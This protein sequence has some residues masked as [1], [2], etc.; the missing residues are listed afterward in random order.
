MSTESYFQRFKIFDKQFKNHVLVVEYKE[1]NKEIKN[2]NYSNI[3]SFIGKVK[4]SKKS[5]YTLISNRAALM[6]EK[7]LENE[8]IEYNRIIEN[9]LEDKDKPYLTLREIHKNR[10]IGA[11]YKSMLIFYILP[12][13]YLFKIS[14]IRKL[15]IW[16]YIFIIPFMIS[17]KY[18]NEMIKQYSTRK[19]AI[20]ML[21]VIES[22]YKNKPEFYQAYEKFMK[23]NRLAFKK[24]Q[25][26]IL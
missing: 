9:K 6:L 19:E 4:I 1:D 12:A 16:R 5:E 10:A 8:K 14:K 7:L 23:E 25:N 18:M 26:P 21:F 15:P 11:Y 20:K 17:Y 3:N 22:Y 2:V 24:I 13:I